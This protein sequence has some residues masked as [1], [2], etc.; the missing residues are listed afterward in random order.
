MNKLLISTVCA[1]CSVILIGVFFDRGLAQKRGFDP[2]D[3]SL[4]HP[5]PSG[6]QDNLRPLQR[7]PSSQPDGCYRQC[8][9]SG[10]SGDICYKKC[11]GG[12]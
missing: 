11:Y 5:D 6:G 4:V 7:V 12:N 8:I 3:T 1:V 9:K 10:H 2:G